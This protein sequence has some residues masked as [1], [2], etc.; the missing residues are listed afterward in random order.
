ME[1]WHVNLGFEVEKPKNDD[2]PFDISEALEQYAA[3]MSA[4]QDMLSGSVSLSLDSETTLCAVDFAQGIV[5]AEFEAADMEATVVSATV[6]TDQELERELAE[7]VCP[8]VLGF[9]EIAKLAGLSRQRIQQLSSTDSFP[10]PVIKTALGPRY[11][12][13]PVKNG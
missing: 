4:S 7:P 6:Q 1:T 12:E 11:T 5:S 2:L 13:F 3:V 8:K 9:A 10:E